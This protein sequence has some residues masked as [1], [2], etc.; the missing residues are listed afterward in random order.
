VDVM[1]PMG[2]FINEM[3]DLTEPKHEGLHFARAVRAS[4]AQGPRA[5]GRPSPS[6]SPIHERALI[7]PVRRVAHSEV[8]T[9][10]EC[11]THPTPPL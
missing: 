1:R 5:E 11:T 7:L 3:M 4:S 2:P 6:Q 8:E 9:A 10:P